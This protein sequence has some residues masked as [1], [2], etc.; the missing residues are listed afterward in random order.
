MKIVPTQGDDVESSLC[1]VD[2][3]AEV[4]RDLLNG[5]SE[6]GPQ[7]ELVGLL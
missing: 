1:D 7:P 2:R 5:M 6:R 3:M 4:L